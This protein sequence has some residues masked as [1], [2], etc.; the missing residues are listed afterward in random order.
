MNNWEN[1]VILI[2]EG[3]EN[4]YV[5]LEKLLELENLEDLDKKLS[6]GEM[7]ILPKNVLLV[8]LVRQGYF[9]HFHKVGTLRRIMEI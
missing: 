6:R 8:K 3:P 1:V 7:V 2:V 5:M 9:R 4:K